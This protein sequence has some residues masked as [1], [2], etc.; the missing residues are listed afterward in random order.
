MKKKSKFKL[1]GM[2][3][4]NI[5][6][7][8]TKILVLLV[9]SIFLSALVTT[10]MSIASI[11]SVGMQMAESQASISVNVLKTK[12][13]SLKNTLKSSANAIASDTDFIKSVKGKS[14]MLIRQSAT[15]LINTFGVQMC[16]ITDEKG[17]VLA[18]T[19]DPMKSGDSISSQA[20]VSAALKGTSSANVGAD[21]FTKLAVFDSE[22]IW[23]SG[24]LIGTVTIG[25]K[26][27]GA[28][29]LDD[30]KETTGNEFIIFAGDERINTTLKKYGQRVNGIKLDSKISDVVLHKRQ[31]YKGKENILGKNYITYYAPIL[32]SDGKSASG[33][34]FAG[35]ELLKI[36]KTNNQNILSNILAGVCAI[37]LF[38]VIG[39]FVIKK[40]LKQPLVKMLKVTKAI[41][42]G[43]V[44]EDVAR[45]LASIKSKDEMG[46]L[47]A[48]MLMAVRSLQSVSED[49]N[50][51]VE[52]AAAHDLSVSVGSKEYHGIYK[53]IIEIIEQL[54]N[55]MSSIIYEMRKAADTIGSSTSHLSDAAQSLAQG[56]AEQAGSTEELA[57]TV[58][59]ISEQIQLSAKNANVTNNLT[60]ESGKKIADS[61]SYMQ[62]MLLAMQ[63]IKDTSEQISV[64]IKTI[65]DIAFQTNIL[66]LNAAIEA[67]RAGTAGKGFAVVADEVRNLANLS[68]AAAQNSSELIEQSSVSVKKGLKIAG[69]TQESLKMVV[70]TA[71]E[72]NTL[73]LNI[74]QASLS[75]NDSIQ[76][77]NL[78]MNQISAVVQTNSA[79]AEETAAAS[80]ELEAQ[81]QTLIDFVKEYKLPEIVKS[82]KP[83]GTTR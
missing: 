24:K 58:D 38:S 51:L 46:A 83:C 12:I 64:I 15:S 47:S 76:L 7:L 3:P 9:T 62:E 79:T 31:P 6:L 40:N 54:F 27:D 42:N 55:E 44:G 30:L 77:V 5:R 68:A 59:K 23:D 21:E 80:E 11:N 63:E 39:Y 73:V 53:T 81:A 8:S 20:T 1:K 29:F 48:S 75:Q 41:E 4:I 52:A 61:N 66:A 28:N 70:E 82:D 16:T 57:S 2:H 18:R 69:L 25:Y 78:G 36:E 43:D 72:S 60:I 74:A 67:A 10:W 33:I 37:L 13:D 34:M 17:Y 65:N 35:Y 14:K 56:A 45:E 71:R 32:S 49:A 19:H 26:L 50:I 22:P